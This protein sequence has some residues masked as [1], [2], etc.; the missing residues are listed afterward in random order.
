M[1]R[2]RA[3]HLADQAVAAARL[4]GQVAMIGCVGADAYGQALRQA[5][6][7]EGID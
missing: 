7:D 3:P 6:A 2:R 5:L 1:D 4:G